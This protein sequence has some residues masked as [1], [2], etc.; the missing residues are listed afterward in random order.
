[1]EA[2]YSQDIIITQRDERGRA[3]SSCSMPYMVFAMLDIL[4]PQ[5][6]ERVLEIGT[7]TGW[8]AAL[9]AHRLGDDQVCVP[10]VAT[11][12][13]SGARS[14]RGRTDL[15]PLTER[16]RCTWEMSQSVLTGT[17]STGLKGMSGLIPVARPR[18]ST[19][20][21]APTNTP[22]SGSADGPT[23]RRA[24]LVGG[25]DVWEVIGALRALQ[26]ESS[27]MTEA[28][29]RPALIEVTG[30]SAEQVNTALR[31]YVAHP[32]S[33]DE[34]IA[35]QTRPR[36]PANTR[37]GSHSTHCSRR[38]GEHAAAPGH[39][40]S[41]DGTRALCRSAVRIRT[42]GRWMPVPRLSPRCPPVS[43]PTA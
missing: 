29:L 5:P 32:G 23:G 28:R 36:P 42:L 17:F 11:V 6:G 10:T 38:T 39:R 34:W 25:P 21:S 14:A 30:L 15:S 26:E 2:A 22:G 18:R 19:R 31:Y 3:S 20:R 43:D 16:S 41:G 24:V 9:L 13:R 12:C 1:M 8:N 27:S 35:R 40:L 4:D 33:I 37:Y 7:G